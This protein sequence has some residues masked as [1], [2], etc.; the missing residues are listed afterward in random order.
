VAVSA[1]MHRQAEAL[2]DA[3]VELPETFDQIV[4]GA[5][6]P[7]PGHGA[8]GFLV[9]GDLSASA[10]PDTVAQSLATPTGCAQFSAPRAPMRALRT[11]VVVAD[12]IAAQAGSGPGGMFGPAEEA[13]LRTDSQAQAR[14]IVQAYDALVTCRFNDLRLPF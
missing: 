12:W 13:W 6:T 10:D 9:F 3:G 7:R 11:Q 4:P 1:E 8:V 14:W 2:I 5:A